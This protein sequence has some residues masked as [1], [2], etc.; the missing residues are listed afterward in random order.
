MPLIWEIFHAPA[1]RAAMIFVGIHRL[2]A[3]HLKPLPQSAQEPAQECGASSSTDSGLKDGYR[4]PH[5]KAPKQIGAYLG[6]TFDSQK[7]KALRCNDFRGQ[8]DS[9]TSTKTPISTVFIK[10]FGQVRTILIGTCQQTGKTRTRVVFNMANYCRVSII[11]SSVKLPAFLAILPRSRIAERAAGEV[12]HESLFSR[13]PVDTV[14]R[15][16]RRFTARITIV[17]GQCI[18]CSESRL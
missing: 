4:R 9:P 3:H 2:K 16:R 11:A 1:G 12:I 6:V 14:D 13:S 17:A 7:V 5:Y 15:H 10:V 8:F 18:Q